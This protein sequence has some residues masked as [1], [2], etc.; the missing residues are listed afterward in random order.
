VPPKKV[1]NQFPP[2]RKPAAPQPPKT[3]YKFL[4]ICLTTILE[5][6]TI[7]NREE[8]H[9]APTSAGFLLLLAPIGRSKACF[10]PVEA[11]TRT[12][13]SDNIWHCKQRTYSRKNE[14]KGLI[15]VKCS[16]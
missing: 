10:W 2:R 4:N 16:F 13:T 5:Y 8:P 12:P 1:S 3:I 9:P 11:Q 15:K 6:E 14:K 7:R